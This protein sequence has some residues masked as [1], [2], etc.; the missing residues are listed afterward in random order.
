MQLDLLKK[1]GQIFFIGFNGYTLSGELKSFLKK[2]QPGG[3]ILF[4]CNIKS[5]KQVQKLI[6]DINE[7]LDIKPFIAVDQEGGAVER[8]RNICTS[9]PS[10]W[11][12][13]K[14]GLKELLKSQEIIINELLE[15]GFNM[16]LGPVVDINSNIENPVIGTRSI[17][18]NPEIVSDYGLEIVNL[19]L[20][21]NIIPVIKHFPG[22]G[23]ANK[24]SHFDL[25]V[26]D[27]TKSEL[28][29]FELLPF[30]KCA[31]KSP[32][33]MTA[34]LQL[35]KIEKDFKKPSSLSRYVMEEMIRK[36]LKFKGL[37]IT[38]ELNMKG[39]T[40]NY[41]LNDA[42][43]IALMNGAD[44]LLYNHES[45]LSSK[46]FNFLYYEAIK[47]KELLNRIDE[48]YKRIITLK[49]KFFK[50]KR[51]KTK[52]K[53]NFKSAHDLALKVVHWVK[54]DIFYKKPSK[55]LK[56]DVIYPSTP[57][58]KE[59]Y[60][61][62]IFNKVGVENYSLIPYELNPGNDNINEIT[63][64]LKKKSIKVLITYDSFVRKNQKTLINKILEIDPDTTFIS[65][66]LEHDIEIAPK[67]K[68]FI[69]GYA[70]N[71]ISLLAS[72]EKLLSGY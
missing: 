20:K 56:F 41:K 66:G 26:I 31:G 1:L 63:K 3:I 15:L 54:K 64:N 19:Y 16:N 53:N 65:V 2:V 45:E 69:A 62:E 12:L 39:V 67:I 44:L 71:Y 6:S 8:L 43:K 24:D 61:T 13:S 52:P 21:N 46:A 17:S 49:S 38:D 33:I 27:K 51:K 5:K 36:D 14:L 28:E 35:P 58:L 29:K 11:G 70:P 42:S 7:I 47:E 30:K 59:Y 34:H 22:H 37:I 32:C 23:D 40:K 57:K 55:S 72:F 68:N 4:E 60:L 48:S 50:K 18:N 10:L 25:P 9:T